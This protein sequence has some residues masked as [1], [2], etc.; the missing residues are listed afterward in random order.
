MISRERSGRG[1]NGSPSTLG[2]ARGNCGPELGQG[3]PAARL[4]G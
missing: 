1:E 3:C 4:A 2:V